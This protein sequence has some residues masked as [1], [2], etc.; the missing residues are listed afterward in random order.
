M[1]SETMFFPDYYIDHIHVHGLSLHGLYKTSIGNMDE[2]M[3]NKSKIVNCD[4]SLHFG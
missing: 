2:M 1:E 3:I 4:L